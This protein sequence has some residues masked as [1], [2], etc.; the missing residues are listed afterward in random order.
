MTEN[1]WK[2]RVVVKRLDTLPNTFYFIKEA[3]A[4]R[5][6]PDI[7]GVVNGRFFAWELKKSE[8]EAMKKT[9]RNVLQQL[10]LTKI[11]KAGGCA[12]FVYPENLEDA[13]RELV[14]ISKNP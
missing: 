1:E 5:G 6:L 10:I 9:G 11:K 13:F 4:L 2:K 3:L 12:R 14:E 7:M 8:R